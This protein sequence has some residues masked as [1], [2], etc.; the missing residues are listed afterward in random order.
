MS[1]RPGVWVG[2]VGLNTNDLAGSGKFLADLGMR[3]VF[4]NESIVIYELRGGTHLIMAAGDE[5][6]DLADFDFM[7]ED[8]DQSHE[9]IANKGYTVS[10]IERG[11]IHDTFVVSEPGGNRIRVNSSHVEDHNIV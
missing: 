5:I 7:V 3:F 2:H 1:N 9:E 6:P 4:S 8:V 10:D 11:S